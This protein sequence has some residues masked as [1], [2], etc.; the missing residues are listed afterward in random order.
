[1]AAGIISGVVS[2][3]ASQIVSQVA[4][5]A[6]SS[7]VAQ[8][9]SSNILGAMTN[10]FQS[11]FGNAL[12][13]MIDNSPLPQFLKD[14]SK[15]VVDDV[16]SQSQMKTTPEAQSAVE[17]SEAGQC[18]LSLATETSGSVEK[19]IERMQND[20]TEEAKGKGQKGR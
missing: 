12:K 11:A 5:Q 20:F 7:L 13:G 3:L 4:T 8:F 17:N 1:M 6:I 19:L 14:A 16:L 2:Q 9:G 15:G 18:A 10:I